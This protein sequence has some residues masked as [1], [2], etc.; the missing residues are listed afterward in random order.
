[1]PR[2]NL[3]NAKTDLISTRNR[4]MHGLQLKNAGDA[5][6]PQ[7]YVTLKQ[8]NEYVNNITNT[9]NSVAE[10]IPTGTGKSYSG[11]NITADSNIQIIGYNSEGLFR[12]DFYAY[13]KSI[14]AGSVEISISWFDNFSPY[15]RS[16]NL[17]ID[18]SK[19][20]PAIISFP[21]YSSGHG[22]SVGFTYL[23]TVGMPAYGYK[24]V[25]TQLA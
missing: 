6:D 19:P 16:V 11:D 23:P 5:T 4:D 13:N 25:V 24:I 3:Q 18:L 20:D 14:G 7:D 8:L 22:V 21:L 1:M 2:Q 12:V 17:H 10:S 9:I 15:V